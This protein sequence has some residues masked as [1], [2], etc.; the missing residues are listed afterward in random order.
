MQR[1]YYMIQR[2]GRYALGQTHRIHA[3]ITDPHTPEDHPERLWLMADKA[4]SS[5]EQAYLERLLEMAEDT[6]FGPTLAVSETEAKRILDALQKK[7]LQDKADTPDAPDHTVPPTT[8]PKTARHPSHPIEQSTKHTHSHH[9]I[10]QSAKHTHSHHPIE[11]SAKHTH[12]HHP[13]EQSAKHTHSHHPIEQSAETTAP[14][15]ISFLDAKAQITL[16]TAPSGGS[17]RH[18]RIDA[19]PD[20]AQSALRPT[21][22]TL[23]SSDEPLTGGQEIASNRPLAQRQG[24]LQQSLF[25]RWQQGDILSLHTETNGDLLLRLMDVDALQRL[26]RLRDAFHQQES[27]VSALFSPV[28]LLLAAVQNKP[29]YP[30]QPNQ[31]YFVYQPIH[32]Y[33]RLFGSWL[34]DDSAHEVHAFFNEQIDAEECFLCL[35]RPFQSRRT[36]AQ[37]GEMG[38]YRGE[39]VR[40]WVIPL[41]Q[42]PSTDL[43]EKLLRDA[44]IRCPIYDQNLGHLGEMEFYFRLLQQLGLHPD[45]ILEEIED[46]IPIDSLC[47]LLE[48][49]RP[50]LTPDRES[51]DLPPF[52]RDQ[53]DDF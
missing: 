30:M 8:P 27:T 37:R 42:D 38:T 34:P 15:Q 22:P 21:H 43:F 10:E 13:I 25:G 35:G 47:R 18:P 45:H 12:S 19:W 23:S 29:P 49:D 33:R 4:L 11:Q 28:D 16:P 3:L 52:A 17:R 6:P 46:I 1:Y 40:S 32:L 26:L 50:P 36:H 2:D 51:D 39:V 41:L 9:P 24:L 31:A 14:R 48:V 53:D 5:S 44:Q 7:S 20:P